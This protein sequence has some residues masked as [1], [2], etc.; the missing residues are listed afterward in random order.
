M[1]DEKRLILTSWIKE[2]LDSNSGGLK[3]TELYSKVLVEKYER[4]FVGEITMGDIDEIISTM[5]PEVMVLDYTWHSIKRA[6]QF[7]YTP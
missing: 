7:I 4:G 6:K 1:N 2:I 3:S 5:Y